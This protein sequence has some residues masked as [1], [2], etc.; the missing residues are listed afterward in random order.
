MPHLATDMEAIH[1]ATGLL[2]ELMGTAVWAIMASG[3]QTLSPDTAMD[4]EDMEVMAD[5]ADMDTVGMEAMVMA[6]DLLNPDMAMDMEDMVAMDM[7]GMVAMDMEGMVVTGT[8]VNCTQESPPL[9]NMLATKKMQPQP[10]CH[11][12]NQYSST[13]KCLPFRVQIYQM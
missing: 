9:Q 3:P 4:M 8:M 5:M 2:R 6:R 7:E 13:H 10:H 1:T 12:L 11:T